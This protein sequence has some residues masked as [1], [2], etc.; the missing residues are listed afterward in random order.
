MT[1]DYHLSTMQLDALREV[2]HIGAG[3]AA[4]GLSELLKKR[5]QLHLPSAQLMDFAKVSEFL[6]GAGQNVAAVFFDVKGKAAGSILLIFPMK[7][8]LRLSDL[9]L[10]RPKGQT[11]MGLDEMGESCLKE[12]GNI[13]CGCYLSVLSEMT[14]MKLAHSV[15]GLAIDMLEA[16]LDGVLSQLSLVVDKALILETRLDVQGEKVC[17][18]F[19]FLPDPEGLRAILEAL[20]VE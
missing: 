13:C 12:I 10:A 20:Q 7:E 16:V 15:P 4:K 3:N 5:I 17:G 19:L 8:A 6:G 1:N 9:L 14:R 2:A 18:H 11:I